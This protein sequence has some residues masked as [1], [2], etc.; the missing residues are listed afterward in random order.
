MR[1]MLSTLLL[2]L[3][4]IAVAGPDEER[5]ETQDMRQE[6]LTNLYKEKSETK[7]EIEKSKGYAV[8]SSL[9]VN[10]LVV[11]T[12]RGSGVLRDNRSGKDIYMSLFSAGGG[13]GL[14][15]KDFRVVFVFNDEEALD[16]FIE[17]GW[18]FSAQADAKVE[19]DEDSG[20]A[21]TAATV[22]PGVKIYQMTEEGLALQATL[23]GTKYWKDDDLN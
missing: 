10:L 19:T 18:D 20:G 11:S 4:L 9:G 21:E 17:S 7:S 15:V 12:G 6:V 16:N 2:C 14:G 23:Q 8:F 1:L 13:I 22:V 5:K 3:P